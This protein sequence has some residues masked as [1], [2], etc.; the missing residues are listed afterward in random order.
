LNWKRLLLAAVWMLVMRGIEEKT[1]QKRTTIS[2]LRNY[3]PPNA[4]EVIDAGQY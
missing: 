3:F 4:Y 1:K 2:D